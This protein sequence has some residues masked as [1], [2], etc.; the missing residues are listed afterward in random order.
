MGGKAWLVLFFV[1]GVWVGKN[2]SKIRKYTDPYTEEL[3]ELAGKGFNEAMRLVVEQKERIE[4]TIAAS[5]IKRTQAKGA[6]KQPK[7]IRKTDLTVFES[8]NKKPRR[9][10]KV[11][12]SLISEAAA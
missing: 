10:K 7:K 8:I 11:K 3:E 4:D 2:W 1:G 6:K 5:K 12:K 9:K